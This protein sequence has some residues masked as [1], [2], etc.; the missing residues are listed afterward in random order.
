MIGDGNLSPGL[1]LIPEERTAMPYWRLFYHLIWSTKG[2]LPLLTPD[3]EPLIHDFVRS[4]AIGLECTVF[5]LNGTFDHVHMVVAIPP[6]LAV[7]KL[8]EQVKGVSATHFNKQHEI[9]G[10]F[11]SQES[12]GAFSF[13]AKRLPPVVAYVERQKEHHRL[14][15]TIAVLER[16]TELASHNGA[17]RIAESPASYQSDASAYMLDQLAAELVAL[18]RILDASTQA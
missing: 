5:A 3:V 1:N 11:A 10:L 12:Y 16:D 13:D 6:K 4:K 9:E 17:P 18:D 15:T 14:H 2:R 8:V 7:A